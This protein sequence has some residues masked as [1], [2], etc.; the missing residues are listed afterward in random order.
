MIDVY[1]GVPGSGKSLHA[2]SD[3]RFDL[4]LV[5]REVPVIANFR[6]GPDAPV[7]HPERFLYIPNDEMSAG[8]LIDFA[9]DWWSDPERRFREDGIHLYID[10]CQ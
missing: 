10:E 6:L 4:N 1:T 3:I 8:K 7:A 9:C 2:A 5:R